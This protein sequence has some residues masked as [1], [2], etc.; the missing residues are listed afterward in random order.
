MRFGLS[1]IDITPPFRMPMYGYGG[2]E[3]SFDAVNDPVTFTALVLEE[4]GRRALIGAADLCEYPLDGSALEL[5]EHLGGVVGC[6]R[7]NVLINTS[8][9]HGGPAVPGRSLYNRSLRGSSGFRRY[10]DWLREQI[11]AAAREAAGSLSEGTLWYGEGKTDVPLNRRPERDGRVVNAPNPDGPF[12]DRL[13]VLALR[14]AAGELAAVG[15]RVSCHPVSTGAQHLITSDYPGAWR[16]EFSRAFGPKVTPFF[17]QGAG[18]DARPRHVAEG[19]HWKVIKHA[20]LAAIGQALMAQ[21]LAVLTRGK[22]VEVRDLVLA[23]KINPIQ[24]PC[25]KLY[26]TREALEDLLKSASGYTKLYAE[27]CLRLLAAGEAVPDHAG[28]LVQTLWLNRELPIIGLDCEALIGLG[29]FVEA[30]VAP[31]KAMLLGYTNGCLCY[32]PDSAELKRGGY[33]ASSYVF[34]PWSGP[35]LPGVEHLMAAAVVKEPPA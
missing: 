26:T 3:D 8:H 35:L 18:A 12:D 7:D 20:E 24:A 17:L 30:A 14:D 27:E 33:E 10:G 1:Q 6:P 34:E 2:R 9:T 25:E 16:A 29:R 23:G 28:L 21:T 4:G 13:Q 15:I 11:T 19:D 22:L 31:K 32:V 5:L